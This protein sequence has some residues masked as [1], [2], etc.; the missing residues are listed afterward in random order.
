MNNTVLFL[1][2][3]FPKE[4]VTRVI[5][6]RICLYTASIQ[7]KGIFFSSRYIVTSASEASMLLIQLVMQD[8]A[9]LEGGNRIRRMRPSGKTK[10][11]SLLFASRP[12][13]FQTVTSHL[14]D[15]C[16]L[17]QRLFFN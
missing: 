16:L 2:L 9:G 13:A 15:P 17:R 4:R 11:M 7:W 14:H 12:P 5:S 6:L 10:K 8:A 1:V 3:F